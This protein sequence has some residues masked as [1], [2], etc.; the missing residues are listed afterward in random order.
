MDEIAPEDVGRVTWRCHPKHVLTPSLK[1][2]QS[3]WRRPL[4]IS[5]RLLIGPE[6]LIEGE[7]DGEDEFEDVAV[8]AGL[9]V[10]A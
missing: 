2:H 1:R 3:Y 8:A 6:I 9:R 4:L 5:F 7:L 10:G